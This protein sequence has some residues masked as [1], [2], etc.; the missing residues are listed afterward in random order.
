MGWGGAR[1]RVGWG[2]AGQEAEWGGVGQE[3]EWS[4]VGQEVEWG[5]VWQEAEW[6]GVGWGGARG[7]VEWG[8]ARGRVEWGGARGRVG[9]GGARSIV[10]WARQWGS[11]GCGTEPK[12][13]SVTKAANA[14]ECLLHSSP[15]MHCI[16]EGGS[17]SFTSKSTGSTEHNTS[18]QQREQQQV[19]YEAL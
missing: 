17:Y 18:A 12:P 1:G 7:R 10:G 16:A 4:G 13:C 8:G 6:G 2:G 9:W 19:R 3:A 11:G 15:R 5:G 14:P